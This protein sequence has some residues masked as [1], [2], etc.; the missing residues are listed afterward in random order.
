MNDTEVPI[1]DVSVPE[2]ID[3]IVS[4]EA[5]YRASQVGATPYY[6]YTGTGTTRMT[7]YLLMGIIAVL[8]LI[9]CFRGKNK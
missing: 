3:G 5:Y 7:N 8:I 2:T 6:Y 4:T 1:E 9:F